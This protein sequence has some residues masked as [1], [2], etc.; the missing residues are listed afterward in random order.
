MLYAAKRGNLV[1]RHNFLGKHELPK[2]IQ[3]EVENVNSPII[4]ENVV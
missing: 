2:L 3:E 1:N 4:S